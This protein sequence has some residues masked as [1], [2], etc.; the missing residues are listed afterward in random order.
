MRLV[1]E[2]TAD[3]RSTGR[4]GGGCLHVYLPYSAASGGVGDFLAGLARVD[5]EFFFD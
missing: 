2:G 3:L 1:G 4:P 5:V